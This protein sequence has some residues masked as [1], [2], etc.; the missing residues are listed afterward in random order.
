MILKPNMRFGKLTTITRAGATKFKKA[1][2]LCRCDCGNTTKSIAGNLVNGGSRSCGCVGRAK[3][4][5]RNKKIFTKHGIAKT[6]TYHAWYG[7][8]ARCADK[9]DRSYGGRGIKVCEFI[10]SNPHNLSKAIGVRPHSNR[11]RQWSVERID[12][13]GNYSCGKCNQC[14]HNG[15]PLNIRWATQ[16]EQC[17]N[18]RHNTFIE[19]GG[20]RRCMS[21]WA[22]IAGLKPGTILSRLK[23]NWPVDK[24]LIPLTR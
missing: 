21:E 15:W 10:S 14:K 11:S 4:V 22:E 12:N 16:K 20:E 6:P 3:T 9:S 8:L 18:T 13:N 1:L 7:M 24:L 19:I 17:R 23:L 2:W 5:I